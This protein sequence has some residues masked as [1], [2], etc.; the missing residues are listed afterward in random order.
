MQTINDE[1]NSFCSRL[2]L[3]R[4]RKGLTQEDFGRLG[5][6]TRLTQSKYESGESSPNVEYLMKIE[7]YGVDL[8]FLLNC[9]T[10]DAPR[11]STEISIIDS[12]EIAG[13]IVEALET[14]ILEKGVQLSPAKKA[15][16]VSTIYRNSRVNHPVDARLVSDLL[17][18]A[19]S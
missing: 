13:L 16:I 3:E 8:H 19:T 9:D 4:E 10:N 15:H 1:K 18:L 2:R 11:L 6:V 7:P 12:S 17:A 5:G 14:A